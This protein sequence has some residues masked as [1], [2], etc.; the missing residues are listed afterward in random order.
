MLAQG[1]MPRLRKVPKLAPKEI[2]LHMAV[3]DF[4]RRFARPDWRWTHFPAGEHRDVRVAAKLKAMGLQRGWPDFVLIS[5]AGLFHALELKR[6]GEDMT[7]DQ[8]AFAQWCVEK[9]VP[10]AVARSLE[11][12]IGKL[13]KWGA[14]RVPIAGLA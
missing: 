2:A 13:T 3:A 5:P 8:A 14:I 12:A 6:Q 9:G 1:R 4:L 10:H 11:E 7:E